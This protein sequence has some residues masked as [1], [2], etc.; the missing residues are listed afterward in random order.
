MA[1]GKAYQSRR[2]WISPPGEHCVRTCRPIALTQVQA[3]APAIGGVLTQSQSSAAFQHRAG[4]GS[5]FHRLQCGSR[6]V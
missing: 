5:R 4:N 2:D 3:H 1:A 6:A